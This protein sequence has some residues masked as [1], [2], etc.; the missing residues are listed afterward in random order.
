MEAK[1]N[2]LQKEQKWKWSPPQ[3]LGGTVCGT[4]QGTSQE[5]IP[6]G[7][8]FW[9]KCSQFRINSWF[10]LFSGVGK[11]DEGV[12]CG[13]KAKD[14]NLVGREFSEMSIYRFGFH[15]PGVGPRHL[16]E[17]KQNLVWLSIVV[18]WLSGQIQCWRD[19]HCILFSSLCRSDYKD[20]TQNTCSAIIMKMSQKLFLWLILSNLVVK[21]EFEV[22]SN[23]L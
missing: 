20:T 9:S 10:Y 2:L 6:V 21:V 15:L 19:F 23:N 7:F 18:V 12:E 4:L 22:L 8:S 14:E 17:E 16:V 3:R 13:G 5:D 1:T 11:L